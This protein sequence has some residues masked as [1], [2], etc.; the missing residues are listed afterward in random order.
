MQGDLV[1]SWAFLLA[2]ILPLCLLLVG[3]SKGLLGWAVSFSLGGAL[4]VALSLGTFPAGGSSPLPPPA[5]PTLL[6]LMLRELCLGSLVAL[7][8]LLPLAAAG[9]AA[10]FSEVAA[11]PWGTRPGPISTLYLLSAGFLCLTLGIHRSLVIGLHQSVS[12]APLGSVSFDSADFGL[13]VVRLVGEA[14]GLSLALGLPLLCSCLLIEAGLALLKRVLGHGSQL[15]LGPALS[16]P[17]FYLVLGG[18]LW[19]VVT[20]VPS[21]LRHG[22]RLLRELTLRAAS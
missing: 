10:R 8:L 19:P 22:S 2:R 3:L 5:V 13:G 21:A 16:R 15:A 9:W 7:A 20:E 14:F 17:L 6:V 4:A 11:G 12:L 1:L 18:L